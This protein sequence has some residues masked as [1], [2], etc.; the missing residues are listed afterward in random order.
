[1][2]DKLKGAINFW[3]H[4]PL[5]AI[6]VSTALPLLDQSDSDDYS[7]GLLQVQVHVIS[8]IYDHSS[9]LMTVICIG[10][11]NLMSSGGVEMARY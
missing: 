5:R 4:T 7:L 10:T 3:L 2:N 6:Q 9:E 11:R 8:L 1:M